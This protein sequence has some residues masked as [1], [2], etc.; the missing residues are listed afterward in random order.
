MAVLLVFVFSIIGVDGIE[1]GVFIGWL[2][3]LTMPTVVSTLAMGAT[4][5]LSLRPREWGVNWILLVPLAICAV[6][7]AITIISIIIMAAT[8]FGA[9]IQKIYNGGF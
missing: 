6:N 9:T 5:G 3:G 4:L 8:L 1:R 7:L 2:L